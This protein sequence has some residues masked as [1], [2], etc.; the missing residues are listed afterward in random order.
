[1]EFQDN[2]HHLIKAID[3][4]IRNVNINYD[5]EYIVEKEDFKSLQMGIK[6][7]KQTFMYN[8]LLQ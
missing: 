8:S 2:F 4:L 5:G 6:K 1:M 3:S 7:L